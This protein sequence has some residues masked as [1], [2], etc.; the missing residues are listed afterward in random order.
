MECLLKDGAQSSPVR[1]RATEASSLFGGRG[2]QS[3]WRGIGQE[4]NRGIGKRRSVAQP[5]MLLTYHED[6]ELTF[7]VS[8]IPS[9]VIE[10]PMTD[11]TRSSLDTV[12]HFKNHTSMRRVGQADESVGPVLFLA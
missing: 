10:T 8:G 12:E 1:P 4:G 7:R 11:V 6:C 3:E 9:G 2:C 5:S